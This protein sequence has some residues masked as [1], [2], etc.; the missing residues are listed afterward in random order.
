[1]M[2][3]EKSE[4]MLVKAFVEASVLVTFGAGEVVEER[5]ARLLEAGNYLDKG[6]RVTEADLDGIAA[7]FPE[8]GVPVKVEHTDSP[9]DPLGQVRRVWRDGG[10]LL[11]TL[12]FPADLAGFLRRR[13]AARLSVG[14]TREPLTLSEVSLVL[15]PRVASA[16]LMAEG[17]NAEENAEIARLRAE[18]TRREVN[19]QI[20]ALKARGRLVPASEGLARA[21]L[22]VGR[23]A[24]VTLA[25]GPEPVAEVFL[26][27]LERQP[28]VVTFGESVPS[29]ED[30]EED[31]FTHSEHTFLKQLG[32]RPAEVAV[33]VREEREA[34]EQRKENANAH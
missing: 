22:S 26:R 12:V 34:K 29:A 11:G 4:Q 21:L 2:S 31:E 1:M 18:L 13:G 7:R 30:D 33:R 17:Q 27:F 20:E 32:V 14:L 6:L 19:G 9:L 16:T 25:E 28:P 10:A 3:E 23:G 24:T 15:K 5:P 8:G